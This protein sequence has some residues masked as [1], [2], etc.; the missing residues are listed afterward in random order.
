MNFSLK[1][2]STIYGNING[3]NNNDKKYK[4]LYMN[5]NGKINKSKPINSNQNIE[6]DSNQNKE[7][8]SNQNKEID[9]NQNKEFDN[10]PES[11][12]Y[13][14]FLKESIKFFNQRE[15]FY[16]ARTE[17]K[18]INRFQKSFL[19]SS[20]KNLDVI[21]KYN[22]ELLKYHKYNQQLIKFSNKIWNKRYCKVLENIDN[23]NNNKYDPKSYH[24]NMFDKANWN[25]CIKKHMTFFKNSMLI[26][27]NESEEYKYDFSNDIMVFASYPKDYSFIYMINKF[28]NY[29][30][31][32]I[33]FIYS[34]TDFI[35]ENFTNLSLFKNDKIHPI[36]I[37]NIGYDFNKYYQGIKIIKENNEDYN[38]VWLINDSFLITKWNFLIYNLV[39]EANNDI[40]GAFLSY[41]R[42]M[43]LQSYLL[44]MN[45]KIL[46]YYYNF[47][48][49][50][51]F[52]EIKSNLDK[53]KLIDHLEVGLCNYIINKGV[54]WGVLFQIKQK[55]NE[56]NPTID[57]GCHSGIIKKKSFHEKMY[58]S[59][60]DFSRS[61]SLLHL[62]D[63]E[64]FLIIVFLLKKVGPNLSITV[65]FFK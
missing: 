41:Q 8:D 13:K 29:G 44:I 4:P 54:N 17:L 10:Y 9:S 16:T 19:S 65:D 34:V 1:T 33:Y 7:I 45:S 58:A 6:I 28:L 26:N 35:D 30:I 22:T 47:L 46:E 15:L 32:K 60:A 5:I 23:V 3:N 49:K 62:N 21:N 57:Y 12:E 27:Y 52:I 56:N 55:F 37:K 20:N 39:R 11:I 53:D 43:H 25:K 64:L 42:K 18:M 2:T 61:H 14:L 24:I 48:K 36:E 59:G 50:Y 51:K 63:N 31:K 38:K 40:I